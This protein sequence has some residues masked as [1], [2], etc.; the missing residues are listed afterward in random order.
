MI[1]GSVWKLII[2][3]WAAE[4][5]SSTAQTEPEIYWQFD[6]SHSCD[7][8]ASKVCR[9]QNK[10]EHIGRRRCFPERAAHHT[11][12]RAHAH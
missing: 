5:S 12:A 4:S 8:T 3:L 11:R 7:V 6:F 10:L 1:A 2:K 9:G